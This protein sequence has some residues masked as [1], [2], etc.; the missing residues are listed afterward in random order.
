MNES[1]SVLITGAG[2]GFGRLTAETLLDRG[3][4]VVATMCDPTGADSA[5]AVALADR[6]EGRSGTVHV[7]R[8]DVSDDESV[9][10]GVADALERAGR[11]DVVINNAGVSL[12][13][14]AES[15]T[16]DEMRRIFE[17]N[18][19]GVQRVNR[20]V[21]PGMR[22]A[23]SGVLLHV[24]S[25]FGRFVV[26]YVAPYT[27]SKWALEALVESYAQEL[28]GTG[29]AAVLIE[30]GAFP[31]GHAEKIA[32]PADE[33]RAGTY[34]GL[35]LR[36]DQMF[37]DFVEQL[38]SVAPDPSMVATLLANLAEADPGNLELRYVVDP[39][40]GGEAVE[41]LNELARRER[42]AFFEALGIARSAPPLPGE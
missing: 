36:A 37:G 35:E 12:S 20:A 31:T 26:P 29:V 13:G 21:L 30:P 39:V 1:K 41:S 10:R 40:S 33:E 7:V 4:F 18:V 24:S 34:G 5:A 19:F 16:A 11:L 42:A 28:A 3:H 38:E 2:S 22:A 32:S 15:V 25:T 27:A 17:V 9:E 8:L 14:L 6:A 23:G